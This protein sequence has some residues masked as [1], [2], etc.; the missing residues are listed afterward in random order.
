[1]VKRVVFAWTLMPETETVGLKKSK[2]LLLSMRFDVLSFGVADPSDVIPLVGKLVPAGP[3]LLFETVLPVL[4]PPVDVLNRIVPVAA[5]TAP[6]DEPR[7]VQFLTVSL[8]VPLMKRIVL[9]PAVGSAV[10][11]EIVSESIPLFRP[12]IVTLS[13]PLRSIN[14]LPAV[15]APVTVWAVTGLIARGG[16]G[17]QT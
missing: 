17:S 7:T 5:V 1:M 16:P 15:V 13:T 12:S 10:V 3:M 11:F 2:I 9:V 4:A 14:G 8:D 6:V